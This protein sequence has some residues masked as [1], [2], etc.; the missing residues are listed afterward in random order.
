MTKIIID[1][2]SMTP[3]L[4]GIGRYSLELIKAYVNKYGEDNVNI[5]VNRPIP[6]LPY[7]CN[8]VKYK[9]HSIIDN[10]K[11]TLF[12]S[13]CDYDIFHSTD[14]TGTFWHAKGRKHI[15]TCHDLMYF[16]VPNFF[17][18]NVVKTFLRKLKLK[19][20]FYGIVKD[21]DEIVSVS[22]TTRCDLK[23]IYGVDS[24]VLR[25]GV[26]T[27]KKDLQPESYRH[28]TMGSFFL[29]VGLGMKHKNVDFLVRS[30]L[31]SDTDKKLVIAGKGHTIV[32]S[33][34]IIY[35]GYIEDKYLDFLYRNCAAFIFPSK[36]EGFGLPI[37]EALSYHC[38]VFSSNAGSLGEFSQDMVKF[39]DPY[40]EIQLIRLIEQC[41]SFEVDCAKIDAYLEH[42]NWK[43]IWNE[44]FNHN[45][46]A[47]LE[48]P[49]R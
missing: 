38:R 48:K 20:L 37:L 5:L 31:K 21:A 34:K 16:M 32:E 35:T 13:R 29:Y 2:R 15:V 3:Q 43:D 40:S 7:K 14:L 24:F 30:F 33:D 22:E 47:K 27:I 49:T 39:F 12:I 45:I 18:L 8:V 46:K 41:D 36:Y 42:F 44:F 11:F 4:S 28:L 1:G 23:K 10:V 6:Y 17:R 25:E 26:N 19:I 9:R